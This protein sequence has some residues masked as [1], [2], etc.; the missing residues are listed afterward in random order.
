MN[1]KIKNSII[2]VVSFL[3]ICILTF[4]VLDGIMEFKYT[5]GTKPINTFYEQEKDT[6]DVLILGSSHAFT[7]FLPKVLWDE[8]GYSSYIFSASV[9]PVWNT[10]FY[11]EEALKTQTPKAIVFEGYR[12][13]EKSDYVSHQTAIKSTYG[14]KF[15]F[16]KLKAL[17]ESFS[18]SD[19]LEYTFQFGNYHSRYNE[20]G[21]H[22]FKEYYND[23]YYKYYKGEVYQLRTYDSAK[24]V[25]VS[26]Y[27]QTE[28][29]LSE[30]TEKYYI[31]MIEL[32]KKH[33]IPF[34]TI[35]APY[36]IPQSEY[37]YFKYAEKIAKEHDVPFININ[38]DYDSINLDFKKDF[39]DAT[40]LNNSG[41]KKLSIYLG[42]YLKQNYDIPD[43]RGDE[44]YESWQIYSEVF[45]RYYHNQLKNESDWVKYIKKAESD[46]NYSY[47]MM[48][49]GY[50][51][52]GADAKKALSDFLS[53]LNI[54]NSAINDSVYVIRNGQMQFNSPDTKLDKAIRFNSNT[55]IRLCYGEKEFDTPKEKK[56]VFFASINNNEKKNL[57]VIPAGITLI[58]YDEILEKVIETVYYES[59]AKSMTRNNKYF[60]EEK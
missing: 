28:K 29:K 58:V 25:N 7:N 43:H 1:K 24:R 30:K 18:L 49:N 54:D 57:R 20:L 51:T 52:F 45:T 44:K 10:Y 3:L 12:L 60:S 37:G 46:G 11:L 55:D 47:I 31:K 36:N 21:K 9:Q 34:V 15:S 41:A 53:T 27:D 50:D 40:H 6:V 42:D 33:N 19:F 39:S 5:D 32:A 59:D 26:E 56:N 17:T 35:I 4:S 14:M 23:P 13:V 2:K 38:E 48:I 8:Y 22:D 16:T